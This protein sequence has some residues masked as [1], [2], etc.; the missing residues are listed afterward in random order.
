MFYSSL[1]NI[2]FIHH[3][4]ELISQRNTFCGNF[5]FWPFYKQWEQ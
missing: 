4:K 3:G 1:F 5:V 2:Y